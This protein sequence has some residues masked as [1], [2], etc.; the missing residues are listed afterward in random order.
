MGMKSRIASPSAV[1]FEI[2]CGDGTSQTWLEYEDGSSGPLPK[3]RTYFHYL[4]E[5]QKRRVIEALADLVVSD[6]LRDVS[7]SS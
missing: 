4:P 7:A 3:G 1:A 5:E 2:D 6:V